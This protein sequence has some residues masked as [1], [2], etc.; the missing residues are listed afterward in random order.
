MLH[1]QK[2]SAPRALVRRRF[3]NTRG[4]WH[5]FHACMQTKSAVQKFNFRAPRRER[6]SVSMHSH[7]LAQ[8]KVKKLGASAPRALLALVSDMRFMI[9]ACERAYRPP[10][11]ATGNPAPRALLALVE[12]HALHRV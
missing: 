7:A 3:E 8:I 10:A 4:E 9:I 5:N 6:N 11:R 12:R 2:C 1:T